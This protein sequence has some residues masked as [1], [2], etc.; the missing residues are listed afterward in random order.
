MLDSI[1]ILHDLGYLH[2]DIKPDNF[3]MDIYDSSKIYLIDYGLIK[4]YI[5][6]QGNHIPFRKDL[7]LCGT[8][9]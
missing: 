4:K 6:D 8:P 7:K 3:L 9:R 1:Q 2:R 5:D